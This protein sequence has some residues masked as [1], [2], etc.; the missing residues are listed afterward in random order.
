MYFF[1]LSDNDIFAER[2]RFITECERYFAEWQR[3]LAT[4]GTKDVPKYR[5]IFRSKQNLV[6]IR[7]DIAIFAIFVDYRFITFAQYCNI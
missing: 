4:T 3:N 2:Q 5:A 1:F 6:K 7:R